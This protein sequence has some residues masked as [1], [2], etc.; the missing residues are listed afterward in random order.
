MKH[1]KEDYKEK[2]RTLISLV[3]DYS[4]FTIDNIDVNGPIRLPQPSTMW[5][6]ALNIMWN[7]QVFWKILG[8]V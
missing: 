3:D 4:W 5:K 8:L 1:F 6:Y 7:E 2:L